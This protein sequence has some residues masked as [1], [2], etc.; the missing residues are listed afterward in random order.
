LRKAYL[1][2]ETVADPWF[3]QEHGG[4]EAQLPEGMEAW[5]QMSA[6]DVARRLDTERGAGVE[7]HWAKT[8]ETAKDKHDAKT[9]AQKA[10]AA[11]TAA[12][13]AE[14]AAQREAQGKRP[15]KGSEVTR[16]DGEREGQTATV[17][18]HISPTQ[19]LI[20]YEDGMEELVIDQENQDVTPVEASAGEAS[21]EGTAEATDEG[22]F[23]EQ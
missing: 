14:K 18:R 11:T 10:R 8:L 7:S 13:K 21:T 20:R 6:I 12:T 15:K 16:N 9:E 3:V 2:D 1:A 17:L 4:I 19:L 22:E 23:T 5:P